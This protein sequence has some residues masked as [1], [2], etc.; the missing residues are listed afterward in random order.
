MFGLFGV[1]SVA[2]AI[3][4]SGELGW[5]DAGDLGRTV[6]RLAACGLVMWGLL[7]RER[8]GWWLA[9]AFAIL[10][11][12]GGGLTLLVVERGDLH[13]LPPSGSQLYLAVGMLS[14]AAAIGLLATPA[15]RRY[16]RER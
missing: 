13:W 15:A 9:L 7:R 5:S 4:A 12:V 8:W 11:L 2:N 3:A 14:L 1:A 10:W 16:L 6:L